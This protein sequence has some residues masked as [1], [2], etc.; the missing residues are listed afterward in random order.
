[1]RQLYSDSD[2]VLF[3]ATRP[4][5]LNGIEDIVARPDLA[6]RAIFLTLTPIPEDQ[7]R[8]EGELWAAFEAERPLI[9]GALLDAMVDGLARLPGT[10]LTRYPRMADFAL[11]ATACVDAIGEPGMFMTAYDHNRTDAVTNV[12]E[13]DPVAAA[14]HSLMAVRTMWTGNALTLLG[15]LS[16]VAGERIAKAKTWPDGPRA[17]AGRLRR[18]ATFLRKAGIEVTTGQR[19]GHERS[20]TIAIKK[21]KGDWVRNSSSAS[22]AN[23]SQ[24][25]LTPEAADGTDGLDAKKHTQSAAPKCRQCAGIPDG[26]EQKHIIDGECVWLH[27]ECQPFWAEGDGWGIRR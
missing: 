23:G 11:W 15:A 1:V 10:H 9:L 17:L 16:E 3:E 19:E 6:D 8:P 24:I 2:E 4:V 25:P 21:T 7:R 5:I 22:S 14:V 13:A 12:I 20:R 26:T 27:R 18:A